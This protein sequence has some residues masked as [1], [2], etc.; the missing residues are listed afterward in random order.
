MHD[1]K[2][3]H[4][5]AVTRGCSCLEIAFIAKC[6]FLLSIAFYVYACHNMESKTAIFGNIVKTFP[7][8]NPIP[9]NEH[10]LPRHRRCVLGVN[11]KAS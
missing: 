9:V 1:S 4:I 3:L 10:M 7:M 8:I 6:A 11:I 2:C 5:V